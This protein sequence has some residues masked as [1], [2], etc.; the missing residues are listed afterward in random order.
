MY[1]GEKENQ[2]IKNIKRQVFSSTWILEWLFYFV[3]EKMSYSLPM[4]CKIDALTNLAIFTE[5]HLGW[6]FFLI[7]FIKKRYQHRCF[8]V[9]GVTLKAPVLKNICKRLLLLG[10][11]W[12][13]FIRFWS[14]PIATSFSIF[15]QLIFY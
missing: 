12:Y 3:F 1:N 15:F 5:R 2:M 10:R 13:S 4:F 14:F 8:P 7:N 9:N 6:R 11:H